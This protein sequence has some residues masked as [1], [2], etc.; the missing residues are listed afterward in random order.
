MK[1]YNFTEGVAIIAKYIPEK[2]QSNN[3]DLSASHDQIWFCE[4]D[5]VPNG[6]DKDRLIELGWYQDGESWSC[7]T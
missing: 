5:L 4:Y 1:N 7:N 6:E 2:Q 3:Y